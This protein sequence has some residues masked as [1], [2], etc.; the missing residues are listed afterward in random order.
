MLTFFFEAFWTND[1][2]AGA[3]INILIADSPSLEVTFE[4][5]ECSCI[6]SP[7]A[8]KL[9][10]RPYLTGRDL[11]PKSFEAKREALAKQQFHF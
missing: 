3:E 6:F 9:K 7:A 8:G 1:M 10:A 4:P 11:C 5:R 2:H